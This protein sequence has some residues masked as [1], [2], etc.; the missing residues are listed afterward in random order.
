VRWFSFLEIDTRFSATLR[1]RVT[2]VVPKNNDREKAGS[3]TF[4]DLVDGEE[5]KV[6]VRFPPEPSG[7]LHIGHAKAAFVNDYYR[8]RY[9][10]K[11]ILRFDDTNPSKEKEEY[12]EAI[13]H[14]LQVTMG[15]KPDRVTYTSDYFGDILQKAEDLIK[16]GKAFMDDLTAEEITAQRKEKIPSPNRDNPV[17]KNL[18]MWEALKNAT[19]AGIKYVLRAKINMNSENG[20]M[21]D[22]VIYRYVNFPHNRT[23]DKFKIYPIYNFACPIVDSVEGVTHACRS[24]EYHDSEEQY[25]WFIDNVPGLRPVKIQ[26]FSR[27]NFTYTLMSKRKLNWFVETGKV[28]DWDDPRFPTI[29]GLSRRGLKLPALRKFIIDL[30]NSK[31]TVLMDVNTL[32]AHNKQYIDTLIPRY[33][34]VQK[35][36]LVE[37]I[38]EDLPNNVEYTEVLK[39]KLNETLGFKKLEKSN[40]IFIDQSDV[41]SLSDKE[42]FTIMDWGNL[43]VVDR[44]KVGDNYTTM[45]TKS[46]F[47]G[48]FKKT[49]LKITWVANSP[50]VVQLKLL[51][52]DNLITIPSIPKQRKF[53]TEKKKD[54]KKKEDNKSEEKPISYDFRDYVNNN[55]ESVVYAIGEPCLRDIEIGD[56]VQFTRRG[57]FVFDRV[58]GDTMVFINT[59]DGHV[60][61]VWK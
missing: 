36:N 58:E 56:S 19:D 13:K 32:W 59:P 7:Y 35:D 27:L 54:D 55:S 29:R 44:T 31:N 45:V 8:K 52:Y 9:H 46:N 49:K 43:F 23:K 12:E 37:V 14:D 20:T 51:Y 28:A 26:D 50:N 11:L 21:R 42:E 25:Y 33:S 38:I 22:P 60:K 34:C 1:N 41:K 18:Q 40:K 48:D 15:V 30:G 17:E 6:V 47:G 61:D 16:V 5:G 39:C 2:K 10:G 3:G 24:N 53:A 4:D 57:Y